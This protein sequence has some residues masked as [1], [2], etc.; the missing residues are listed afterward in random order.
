MT[1]FGPRSGA[2]G[3]ADAACGEASPDAGG[4]G[5]RGHPPQQRP[6]RK[7]R[8]GETAYERYVDVGIYGLLLGQAA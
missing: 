3:T 7:S 8:L 6:P 4:R 1:G 5:A 2:H